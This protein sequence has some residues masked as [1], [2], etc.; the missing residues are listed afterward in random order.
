MEERDFGDGLADLARAETPADVASR[1]DDWASRYDED[2]A[3]WGYQV[4]NRLAASVLRRR[5]SSP[6]LDA[7]C[8]TGLFGAAM[9]ALQAEAGLNPATALDPVAGS[10]QSPLSIIGIDISTASIAVAEAGGHYDR[11]VQG[12]LLSRLPWEDG[13]FGAAVCGGV[14]TYIEQP[15]PL[16][17][18]LLR[19]TRSGGSVLF[20]QRTD[21][22]IERDCDAVMKRFANSGCTVELAEPQDYLPGAAEY[23]TEIQVIHGELIRR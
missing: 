21:L 6:I 10:G 18:E 23:G 8:G 13:V 11:V 5:D 22:W 20:T 12:D 2:I 9:A 3:A 17:A 16:L 14:L 4:P 7:G 19:V 15:E 1:Y